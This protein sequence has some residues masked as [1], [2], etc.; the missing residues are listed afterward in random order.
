MEIFV[1]WSGSK[2]QRVAEALADWLPLIFSTVHVSVSSVNIEAGSRW[3][4]SLTKLL[5][6]SQFGIICVTRDNMAAPWMNFEAGALGVAKGESRTVPYLIDVDPSSLK[7]PL[8]QFQAIMADEK[9]TKRLVQAIAGECPENQRPSK[10]DEVYLNWWPKLNSKIEEARSLKGIADAERSEGLRPRVVIDS[11]F[12]SREEDE[13]GASYLVEGIRIVNRG[14][15]PAVNIF[16]PE[17][18]VGNKRARVRGPIPATLGVG[19]TQE[20]SMP[21]LESALGAIKFEDKKKS[22]DG[23]WYMEMNL[24]VEYHDLDHNRWTTKQI[25]Q[26]DPFGICFKVSG[27]GEPVRIG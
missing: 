15:A 5:K 26:Q 24:V 11:Y 27:L 10:L 17:V 9:G 13:S 6:R 23:I 22:P 2:S 3:I 1:S 21:G 4:D 8:S 20:I 12:K 25:L 18:L 16:I 7:G 14:N 19:E